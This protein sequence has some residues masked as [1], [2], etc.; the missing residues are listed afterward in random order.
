MQESFRKSRILYTGRIAAAK[1]RR[2]Y[3]PK[4]PIFAVLAVIFFVSAIAG[5]VYVL[6]LP[7]L[8]IHKI[9][10]AGA[11]SLSEDG[12]RALAT[13]E[14]EGNIFYLI[15][16]DNYLFVSSR[17]IE[18]VLKEKF[19]RISEAKVRKTLAPALDIAI[20]ERDIWGIGCVKTEIEEVKGETTPAKK[21]GAAAKKT[22]PCF[23]IDR[24]GFAFEDVSSFEGGLLPIIYK[25]GSGIIGENI[26]G[27][28]D[29]LFFEEVN[30]LL[31]SSLQ[32]AL[33]SLELSSEAGEDARLALKEGWALL[34]PR[35]KPPST[36]VSVLKTLLA[37]EI[38]DQR[39]KLDYVDLRFGNKVFYKFR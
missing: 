2:R 33:L 37:G 13:R 20:T 38:K 5:A 39:S 12:I 34:V 29:V 23:Y 26:V 8:R 6:R 3:F 36:W 30:R 25:D 22:G 19:L 32:L 15:P 31:S 4:K 11:K 1:P 18:R 21:A 28:Q 16:K 27:E 7:R 24:T 9:K 17:G 14:L 10:V 35:N